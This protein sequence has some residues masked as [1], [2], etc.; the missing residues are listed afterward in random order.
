MIGKTNKFFFLYLGF[1]SLAG[2]FMIYLAA[3]KVGPGVSNDAAEILSVAQNLTK[4]HGLIDFRGVALTQF[5]PLYSLILA[6]GSLMFGRDVVV[7][8]WIINIFVFSAIIWFSGHIF[9][10]IFRDDPILAYIGTFAIFS[11]TSLLKISANIASDPL[12]M[13]IVIFFLISISSYL[14]SGRNRYLLLAGILVV[15]GCFQR[16]AGLSLIPVGGLVLIYKYKNNLRQ[17]AQ[18]SFL[19]MVPTATPIF[20][21]G[22]LHNNPINGSVFGERIPYLPI[23]NFI[24]GVEKLLNWFI[25]S[26][27]ILVVGPLFLFIAILFLMTFIIFRVGASEFQSK[28]NS[29]NILPHMAFLFVYAGVLIFNITP[30]LQGLETDR[31]HIVLLPSLLIILLLFF[32]LLIKAASK[33]F[34]K[35][36]VYL[37]VILMVLV[38][39]LYPVGKTISYIQRS[40]VSGDVSSYNSLN[41][42]N[43]RFT[44]FANYMSSLDLRGKSLYSNGEAAAW[45]ILRVQV[46]PLPNSQSGHRP[47]LTDLEQNYNGWPGTGREGYLIWFNSFASKEYLATPDELAAIARLNQVYSDENGS[48]YSLN[49]Q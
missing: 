8:G 44:N 14:S 24:S 2:G 20:L 25:P 11:S 49:P 31:V 23:V 6:S 39:S 42:A 41:K 9:Y 5:P 40:M 13:L 7:I 43:I 15:I 27:I 12:F 37:T 32:D 21:W 45:F 19:F 30:E 3:S 4:G 29:P 47:T 10:E 26:Q 33:K 28:L 17:A 46:N 22:Y 35:S 34:G 38:W 18:S 1:L 48:I 16:Y 36:G